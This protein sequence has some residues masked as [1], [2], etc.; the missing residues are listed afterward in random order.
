MDGGD[1]A[2]RRTIMAGG[3]IVILINTN[4]NLAAVVTGGPFGRR[5]LAM[6]TGGVF[7]AAHLDN[8]A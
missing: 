7:L 4:T 2:C 1:N 5:G 8:V 3:D 6:V